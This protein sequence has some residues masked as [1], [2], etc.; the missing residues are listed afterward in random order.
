MEKIKSF[1]N[2][3]MESYDEAYLETLNEEVDALLVEAA[4]PRRKFE[5]IQRDA[6]MKLKEQLE[7]YT[8]LIKEKPEKAD[9]YKAQIDLVNAKQMVLL[10][11]ERLHMVKLK[12]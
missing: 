3:L 9:L 12:V 2:F 8:T 1:E 10:A 4:G 11:K 6:E 5:E 7:K